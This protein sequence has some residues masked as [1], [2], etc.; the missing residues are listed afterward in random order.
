MNIPT[1]SVCST[2]SV[3]AAALLIA[4]SIPCVA[5]DSPWNGT[6]KLNQ[7]K[8]TFTGET[9]TI[10]SPSPGKFRFSN[11]STVSYD[12]ACDGK[13]YPMIADRTVSCKPNADG[14]YDAISK[15]KGGTLATTHRALSA[16]GKSLTATS[17]GTQPDGT[18]W[19]ETDVYTRTAPGYGI[20][21]TWKNVKSSN[22]VPD[23]LIVK[24][25][26]P[27]AIH[28]DIPGYK[29][30]LDGKIDGKGIPLTGPS[31]PDG[32]T[33]S[34]K[35]ASATKLTYEVKLKEK[36]LDIGDQTLSADGKTLTDTSW[37]PGKPAEKQIGVY[38]RQ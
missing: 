38:E 20:V 8:S 30:S 23:V 34:F 10:S 7:D 16:D 14:A 36:T 27:D 33:I 17:S 12:F 13:E 31:V 6:W 37:V 4:C 26:A 28:W 22:S 11:G 32:L 21:G 35:K 19:T 1:I 2:A 29:E 25:T 5:A 24:V 9:F 3:Y 15:G 18:P